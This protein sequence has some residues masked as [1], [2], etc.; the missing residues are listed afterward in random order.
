MKLRSA[1][2]TRQFEKRYVK[3][4]KTHTPTTEKSEE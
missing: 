1:K 4:T 3:E 2:H